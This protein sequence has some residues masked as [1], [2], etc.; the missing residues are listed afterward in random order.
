MG[1]ERRKCYRYP[2][3]GGS[4]TVVV[5]HAG[6]ERSARLLNLS[7]DGFRLAMD[8]ESIVEVG[9][10]V[11]MATSNGFH[12]VKVM[13]VARDNGTLQL[14]LQRLQDLPASALEADE[15]RSKKGRRGGRKLNLSSPLAT[16]LVPVVL[17]ALILGTVAW[18]WTTE[19]DPVGTV[20]GDR[21]FV[22]PTTE[23]GAKRRRQPAGSD[24]RIVQRERVTRGTPDSIAERNPGALW[25]PRSRSSEAGDLAARPS[26][27]SEN[28]LELTDA[29]PSVTGGELFGS[30]GPVFDPRADAATSISSALMTANRENK[31]VLVEFGANTC[32]SCSRLNAYF[33]Q[34]NEIAS[35]VQ[36]TFVLV[37]VDM[38]SNQKLVTRYLESD[39][40]DRAPF[41]ALLN[42]EGKVVKR[43]RT[44]ELE[45]GSKLDVGKVKAFLQDWSRG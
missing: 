44:D 37:L 1:D 9:D 3:S 15:E 14:G 36:K 23:Y 17:G 5:R 12:R 22:T 10:I 4:E 34:D 6:V 13:N 21:D 30:G 45:A 27:R 29:K 39:L 43:R 20:V 7:S 24:V 40:R 8:E 16:V 18:T 11:L 38:D 41:L 2:A 42:K 19:A 35:A 25:N 26:D 28:T 32:N 31:R 33:M